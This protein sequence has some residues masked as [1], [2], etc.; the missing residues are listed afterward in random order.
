MDVQPDST[1][2]TLIQQGLLW[3]YVKSLSSYKCPADPKRTSSGL[4]TVRSVSMN[5]WLNPAMSLD[6]QGLS[7]PGRVF[8]KQSDIGAYMSPSMCWIV[9][10]ES[11]RT[12]NDGSLIVS[13]RLSGPNGTTWIDVPASYH[14]KSAGLVYADGHTEIKKWRDNRLLNATSIFI[15]A[16]PS[17]P[18]VPPGYGD[19][20]WLRE[21]TTV[22]P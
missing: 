19:L 6:T 10:D 8:R 22:V 4:P 1:N 13:S 2:V 5:G 18:P 7:A 15:P 9:M 16:D 12:I 20:M 17:V 11:E 3:P 14:N 21:R